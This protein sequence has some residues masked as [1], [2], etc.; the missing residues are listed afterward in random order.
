MQT[1][2]IIER[3]TDGGKEA[4]TIAYDYNDFGVLT[5]YIELPDKYKNVR[6]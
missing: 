2:T 6:T 1:T 5:G 4:R 3:K